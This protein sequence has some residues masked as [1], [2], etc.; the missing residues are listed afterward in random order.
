MKIVYMSIKYDT[1]LCLLDAV[2]NLMVWLTGTSFG[3]VNHS[4]E[5]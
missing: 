2:I 5:S 3:E 4:C 1:V